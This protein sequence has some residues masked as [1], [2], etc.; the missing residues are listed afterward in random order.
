MRRRRVQDGMRSVCD[1]CKE[2][3]EGW[4]QSAADDDG[5]LCHARCLEGDDQE[6]E[7]D[8]L[9]FSDTPPLPGIE[10]EDG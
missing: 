5:V 7:L 6:E 1:R 3:I 4:E 8:E 2:P 9:D 10:D